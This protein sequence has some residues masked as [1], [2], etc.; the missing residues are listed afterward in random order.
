[1]VPRK[2]FYIPLGGV[3]FVLLFL[4]F[5]AVFLLLYVRVIGFAFQNLGFSPVIVGILLAVCLFGSYINIPV[6]TVKAKVPMVTVGY[7]RFFGVVYPIPMVGEGISETTIAVNLGGAIVPIL[8]SLYLIWRVPTLFPFVL[9]A[10]ALV[11]FL[12]HKVA[13]PTSGVGITTPAFLPPIFAALAAMLFSGGHPYIVAYVSGT[14][15][16]LIGADLLNLKAI[17]SLGAPVASI[18]GA[19]TF[20]GIFLTGVL[21]VI[22]ASL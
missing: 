17:P 8:V 15:G 4:L 14:L 18:G 2:L 22:L 6:G 13:K 5:T 3:F 10:V 20:D 9:V 16:T 21:A 19:G 11:S 12:V 7:V 1:M